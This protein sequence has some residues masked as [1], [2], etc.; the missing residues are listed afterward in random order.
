M[1]QMYTDIIFLC[2]GAKKLWENRKNQYF[3]QN[4]TDYFSVWVLGK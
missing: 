4:S 3:K 1:E 2:L